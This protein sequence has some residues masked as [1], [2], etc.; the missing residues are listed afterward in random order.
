MQTIDIDEWHAVLAT[1]PSERRPADGKRYHVVPQDVVIRVSR[2]ILDRTLRV[3][4]AEGAKVKNDRLLR[5]LEATRKYASGLMVDA[6]MIA[7][8]MA[9]LAASPVGAIGFFLALIV[10]WWPVFKASRY[11]PCRSAA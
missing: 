5:D 6:H 2:T 8:F 7:L 4:I 1:Y 9:I 3:S 11:W 10:L